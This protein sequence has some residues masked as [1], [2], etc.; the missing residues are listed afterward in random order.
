MKGMGTDERAIFDVLQSGQ[1][2]LDR[3]IEM[4]SAACT[5]TPCAVAA[6]GPLGV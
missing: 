2:D 3:A 4:N 1:A 6:R 5:T